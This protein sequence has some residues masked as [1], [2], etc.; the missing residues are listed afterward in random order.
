[1]CDADITYKKYCEI[2][3][4]EFVKIKNELVSEMAIEIDT[5]LQ[6]VGVAHNVLLDEM[7]NCNEEA[8]KFTEMDSIPAIKGKKSIL[9]DDSIRAATKVETF[10]DEYSSQLVKNDAFKA[11]FSN[12]VKGQLRKSQEGLSLEEA[13]SLPD[14]IMNLFMEAFASY[15]T[16]SNDLASIINYYHSQIE[17]SAELS[18]EEKTSIY[19]GM[20]VA[21]YSAKYWESCGY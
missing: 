14:Y 2:P 20:V 6:M 12:L 18:E 7:R 19:I 11:E 5:T 4:S 15:T 17:P 13:N 8:L 9:I 3:E 1:M 21:A 10:R 16:D